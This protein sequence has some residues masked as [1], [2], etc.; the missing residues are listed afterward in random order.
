M[1]LIWIHENAITLDHPAIDVAGDGAHAIFIWDTD[2]HDRRGYS[3][4][5][6][7]FIYE[8][9]ADLGIEIVTGDPYSV[10]VSRAKGRPIFTAHTDDPDYQEV[11]EKLNEAENFNPI[12]A[13]AF[14][15]IPDDIDTKRFFRFWNRV[16]KSAV[17]PNAHDINSDI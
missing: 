15:D 1:G 5:R 13:K 4:K 8:C 2:R 10:L 17:N 7:V 11:F 12:K 6:R 16:R 14:V 9:A 3:L